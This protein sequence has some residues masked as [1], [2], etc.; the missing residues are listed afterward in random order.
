MIKILTFST[1][2]PNPCQP[3]HGIF[4]EQ[5]LRKL[6]ESGEVVARVVAPVPWFPFAANSALGRYGRFALVPA[7]ESRH[8]ITVEHPRYPV[9][10]KVGMNLSPLLMVR[11]MRPVFER[12]LNSGYDF[13]LIDAHYFY[14]CGVAAEELGR[15]LGKPVV[16]TAR[17][18]DVMACLR[19]RLPRRMIRAAAERCAGMITVSAD[20]KNRLVMHGVAEGRITVLRNGV[21]LSVFRPLPSH[22]PRARRVLLSV[23]H[24]IERKGHHIAID[25]LRKLP[26]CE[27]II[28]GESGMEAGGMERELKRRVRRLRLGDRVRFIGNV[29]QEALR[30]HYAGADAL[31]LATDREGMPN[32][33]LEA[34]ACGTPVVATPVG[35]IPEVMTVPEA[36]VLMT[37]RTPEALVDALRRLFDH[38]PAR[39]QVRRFAE[40]LGWEPTTRGQIALFCK[41]LGRRTEA[42]PH[43]A[44]SEVREV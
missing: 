15:Q 40:T 5:R 24:L 27:L 3:R 39:E 4:V 9:I 21:D 17:G 35:G 37:E 8:G 36:G 41:V 30:E 10:P 12:I 22:R 6:V 23:G 13:D 31:V 14:P 38:Y 28:I 43:R 25:A 44:P 26:D 19:H 2:Y 33:L 18:D 32:V 20:L 29:P 42:A 1:L 7:V 16:M 34:L 11:A